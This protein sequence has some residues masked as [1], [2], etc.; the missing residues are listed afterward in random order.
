MTKFS[1][2]LLQTLRQICNHFLPTPLHGGQ[3]LDGAASDFVLDVVGEIA[4]QDSHAMVLIVSD[5]MGRELA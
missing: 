2:L 5:G 1:F 4:L 3:L